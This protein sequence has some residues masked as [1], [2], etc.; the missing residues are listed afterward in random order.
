MNPRVVSLKM[1]IKNT[2]CGTFISGDVQMS[3]DEQSERE[4]NRAMKGQ[5]ENELRQLEDEIAACKRVNTHKQDA[6][7]TCSDS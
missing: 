4:K 6:S 7:S 1:Q 2:V 3:G 5:I